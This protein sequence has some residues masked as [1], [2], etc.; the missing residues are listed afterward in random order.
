MTHAVWSFPRA[1]GYCLPMLE[2]TTWLAILLAG[3]IAHS[4]TPEDKSDLAWLLAAADSAYAQRHQPGKLEEVAQK[5]KQA[6]TMA[7]DDYGVL[8]R[9]A[10]LDLWRSDDPALA[11][12]EKSRIGERAWRFAERAIEKNP[13][14]VAGYYYAAFGMGNYSLGIGI[15][16]AI[17]QGIDGKFRQRLGEAERLDPNF[18]R[19]SIF[20]AWGRYYCEVPWPKY[21]AKKSEQLLRKAIAINPD[22][23]RARLFLADL[24]LK[25][26]NPGEAKKLVQAI[27]AATPG[28]Y[29]RAEEE[30]AQAMARSRLPDIDKA[31]Q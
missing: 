15:L 25:E 5:L 31:L 21:D 9:L 6:Q 2:T 13:A 30:R 17:M 24:F 18:E 16:R 8:W 27:L 20:T 22:N 11:S 12:D 26:G 19:G 23:L 3:L 28:A 1:D 10:R 4:S 29:D 7:P 14:G